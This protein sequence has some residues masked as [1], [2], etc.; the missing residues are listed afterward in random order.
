MNVNSSTVNP[1]EAQQEIP[2]I[3]SSASRRW[4]VGWTSLIF[5]ILQSACTLFMAASGL[6][7]L[8]GVSSSVVA[9]GLLPFA[10]LHVDVLRFPMVLL[11]IAGSVLNL[12][13]IWQL[14]RLRA[15]PSSQWRIQA[16]TSKQRRG[17]SL[18]IAL[19][20]VTLLLVVLE[21]SFHIYLHHVI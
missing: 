21:E 4:A 16:L 15:R 1:S 18:Q 2:A 7:L 3:A 14:R 17:E 12:F 5:A 19:A 11:A 20:I 9:T 10:R 6:R 13:V 8:I